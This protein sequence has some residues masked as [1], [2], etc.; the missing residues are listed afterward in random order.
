LLTLANAEYRVPLKKISI[1]ELRGAFFYDTGNVFERPSEFSFKDFTHSAG[2]GI[3][4]QTPLG[5]VR[6]DVGVNLNPRVRINSEG[7][8]EREDSA[9]A[10]F[11]L[12]HA[13]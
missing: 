5:P 3:R 12:G 1:G 11:T 4:F 13:F 9:K 7:I 10:F 2:V 8:P 6:F